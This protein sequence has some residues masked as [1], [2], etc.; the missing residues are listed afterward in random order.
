[1]DELLDDLFDYDGEVTYS[2]P[3]QPKQ[4]QQPE[5]SAGDNGQA[6]KRGHSGEQQVSVLFFWFIILNTIL[7]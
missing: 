4:Q 1:M 2:V 3:D 5:H 7:Y 6:A